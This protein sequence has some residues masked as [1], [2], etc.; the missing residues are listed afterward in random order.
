[1]S[2][3]TMY[4]ALSLRGLLLLPVSIIPSMFASVLGSLFT[5]TG[6]VGWYRT[7]NKPFFTPPDIAFPLVWTFLYA[8]MAVGFWRILRLRPEAGPRWPAIAAFLVQLLINIGWTYAFFGLRSPL[9][10]LIVVG[11]LLV[12]I[13]INIR[14]FQRL[15]P[16]ASY[17]LYPYFAWAFFAMLLNGAIFFLNR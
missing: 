15:D 8:L 17:A 7:L 6:L 12:A 1:M 5:A 4:P 14:V 11:M 16:A 10:G 3:K 2:H 13:A 9:A